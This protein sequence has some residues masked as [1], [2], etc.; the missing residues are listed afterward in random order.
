MGDD[1]GAPSAAA[2]V[3]SAWSRC[4]LH[5]VNA[6]KDRDRQKKNDRHIAAVVEN[7]LRRPSL[8]SLASILRRPSMSSPAL[9]GRGEGAGLLEGQTWSALHGQLDSCSATVCGVQGELAGLVKADKQREEVLGKILADQEKLTEDVEAIRNM[10]TEHLVEGGGK[11]P[12]KKHSCRSTEIGGD[13]VVLSL[14]DPEVRQLLQQEKTLEVMLG[15]LSVARRQHERTK[16]KNSD[17]G[18]IRTLHPDGRFRSYWNLLMLLFLAFS[19]VLAPMRIAW[20]NLVDSAM[21]DVCD[22]LID[23]VFVGGVV[24]NFFTGYRADGA[25]VMNKGH[26]ARNY[27]RGWF[28]IDAI[29]SIP[30][31]SLIVF[32]GVYLHPVL[33]MNKLLRL[34]RLFKIMRFLRQSKTITKYVDATLIRLFEL[35]LFLLLFWHYVGCLWW[36]IGDDR[37][38]VERGLVLGYN[39]TVGVPGEEV[40]PV[41]IQYLASF[42][43]AIMMTTGL[44]TAIGPG[45][46]S[47]QIVYECIVSFMGVCM[48][49]YMLGAAAAEI[50]KMDSKDARRKAKLDAIKQ[51]LASL[52]V[53]LFLRSPIME[54]YENLYLRDSDDLST[55][56]DMPSSLKVQMAVT[57]N[58]EFV[59]SVSYFSNLDAQVIATLVLCLRSRIYMPMEIVIQ[60]GEESR[61]L[62]FVRSGTVQVIKDTNQDGEEGQIIATLEEHACFGEQ[63]F[64]LG[65][66]ALASVRAK[67]YSEI[68]RLWRIDFDAIVNMFP[69]LRVHM[70]GV[71]RELQQQ[72]KVTASSTQ[73]VNAE[74]S[75]IGRKRAGFLKGVNSATCGLL[76]V[77]RQ[78]S[79][80]PPQGARLRGSRRTSLFGA[81]GA[82]VRPSR[83][84][85]LPPVEPLCEGKKST[86]EGMKDGPLAAPPPVVIP[87]QRE[88]TPVLP[89]IGVVPANGPDQM[90]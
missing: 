18:R 52:R 59:R 12:P 3:A 39:P 87:S 44:N 76:Q 70:V 10:L 79:P 19:S 90:A 27:L 61:A 4:H 54:Y 14:D 50:A 17:R 64:L 29:S 15:K 72:Y 71:Q 13:G 48:Q 75:R 49:A 69:A 25:V 73:A 5:K 16:A 22:V 8:S 65:T 11:K 26:I 63:S 47:G 67:H 38:I 60:Q 62:F 74:S 20:P 46:R 43:W 1:P 55:L 77:N 24:I 84:V 81:A 85:E 88:T 56:S 2:P 41:S 40:Y 21:M 89:F 6:L 57:L 28:T 42:Y 31:E 33:T 30:F 86:S 35:V 7:R 53:P 82:R 34:L 9:A 80:V 45:Q 36:Y 68:M 51:C 37:S 78:E 58:A 83:R 32:T 23:V 66:E